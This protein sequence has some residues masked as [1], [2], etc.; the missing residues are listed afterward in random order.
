MIYEFL[1]MNT[2][3]QGLADSTCPL[4]ERSDGTGLRFNE[5]QERQSVCYSDD[6][7]C[8]KKVYVQ[9]ILSGIWG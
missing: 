7:L 6:R 4:E 2:V 9:L 8:V 5:R 1:V 3:F